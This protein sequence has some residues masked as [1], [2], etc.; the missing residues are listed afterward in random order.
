[1]IEQITAVLATPI[2]GVGLKLLLL[3]ILFLVI[4]QA[5]YEAAERLGKRMIGHVIDVDRRRRLDTLLRAGY[6][7]ATVV[8]LFIII[9]MALEL[10]GIN[11]GPVLASAGVAGLAISLGAQTLIRDYL[12]GIMILAEDQFRVGDAV[13]I[14][15]VGGEVVRMTLRTTYLRDLQ[16]KLYTVPNGDVRVI[17]NITRDWARA[18]VDLNLEY[19]ADFAKVERALKQAADQ[20]QADPTVKEYLIGAPETITWNNFTDWAVQ[21]RLMAKTLPGKQWL[22][23]RTL[24]RYAL[25][26]LKA[27]GLQVAFPITVMRGQREQARE[28][29]R[30]EAAETR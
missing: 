1:M 10:L 20:L 8:V 11:I 22:V 14:G 28:Q 5:L 12:S 23:A 24:R 7:S 25:E 3:A 16:G 9:T 19:E 15:G 4:R 29:A 13:E 18:V 6:G 21:V 27:E 26:A 30:E 17:S 2:L